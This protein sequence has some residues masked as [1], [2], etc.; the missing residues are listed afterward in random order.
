MII[1][2]HL[3]LIMLFILGTLTLTAQD[4]QRIETEDVKKEIADIPGETMGQKLESLLFWSQEEKERR[5]P[6]MQDIFPSILVSTGSQIVSFEESKNITPKWEDETTLASYIN[7]NRVKG[8]IVLK[9]NRIKL[10]E[11]AEGVDKET[12]WTSFSVA[13]SVSSMLVG[14]AL[15]DGD[16][17]SLDDPLKKYIS[18]LNGYDYGEVTVRQLLTMTSGI[19]WNEDYVDHNSDVAQMYLSPCE[20]TESH[21]LTYM[22][23]LKFTHEPGTTWNYS[24]GETDLVGILIQKA[25]GKSLAEYLSEKIWKP[26]GMENCAYWLA[27][28]C[29]NLNIGGSGLSAS[30]RDFARLGTLML[31]ENQSNVNNIISKEWLKNAT[32]ILYEVNEQGG[33]YG[34]L[35]W[36]SKDGSYA[37]VGIFGQMIYIDPSKNLVIAQIAAW[38]KAS[39]KKLVRDRYKFIEAVQRAIE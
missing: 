14:V 16:I 19:E 30:L 20:N 27:D 23:P 21:I 32:S 3:F 15:K 13:K 4:C 35:W 33:G 5:F 12:L 29:S 22:K 25:T 7:D 6:I 11:Y 31:R 17:E 24:T 1:K 34:Y 38:P 2:N 8:I 18:E 39:S 28:E 36:R 10:E 26:F 9:D 37:A